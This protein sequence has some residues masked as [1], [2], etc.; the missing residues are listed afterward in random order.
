MFAPYNWN[1]GQIANQTDF[2]ITQLQSTLK[3]D[4]DSGHT[5]IPYFKKYENLLMTQLNNAGATI[6]VFPQIT[7]G[8]QNGAPL[9]YCEYASQV[10]QEAGYP[11]F[12]VWF[13]PASISDVL[14]LL[15]YWRGATSIQKL[16]DVPYNFMLEQNFPNPFNPTTTINYQLSTTCFVTLKVYDMLGREVATLINEKQIQ[17]NYS[18]LFNGAKLSSGVYIYRLFAGNRIATMKMLLLK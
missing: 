4:A 8:D 12:A 6:K 18:L 13:T 11:G 3:S 15:Q 2:M 5:D 10:I 7:L 9:S 1:Y 17:G 14:S 16:N